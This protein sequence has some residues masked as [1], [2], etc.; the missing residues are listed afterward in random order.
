MKLKNIF[1]SLA[2]MAFFTTAQ[3][4]VKIGAN[5]TTI[6]AT[7]NL[8]VEA[9]NGNKTIVNKT[10]GQVTIQD[11][12]QGAGKVLTSDANGAASW[13]SL[14]SARIPRIVFMGYQ[15]GGLLSMGAS[16]T[17]APNSRFNVTPLPGFTGY[18]ATNRAYVI[19]ESGYYRVEVGSFCQGSGTGNIILLLAGVLGVSDVYGVG[20][21]TGGARSFTHTQYYSAGA[22]V[23]GHVWYT[24]PGV[25]PSCRDSYLVVTRLAL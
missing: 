2:A 10:N 8:E 6:G 23:Y 1:L 21:G 17:G 24:D 15:T 7:S 4:Q 3:A 22:E 12:T 13:N 14:E 19:P 18:N 5:P 25:G 20:P 16:T 11:G 9:T